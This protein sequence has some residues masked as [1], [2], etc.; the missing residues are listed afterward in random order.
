MLVLSRKVGEKIL[1]GDSIVI[2]V[3]RLSSNVTR[4]GIE[5]PED[6]NIVRSE[7]RD[8]QNPTSL[9]SSGL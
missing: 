2:T 8:A 1:V 6:V 7:V 4:I 5:A 9:E 3:L